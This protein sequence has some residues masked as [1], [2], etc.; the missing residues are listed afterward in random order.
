MAFQT[1]WMQIYFQA[2]HFFLDDSVPQLFHIFAKIK[3]GIIKGMLN[4][5]HGYYIHVVAH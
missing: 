2:A 1:Y 4:A 3:V 5:I